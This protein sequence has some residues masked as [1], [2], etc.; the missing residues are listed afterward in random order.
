MSHAPLG[1]AGHLMPCDHL[2]ANLLNLVSFH[3]IGRL[4]PFPSLS[5][6]PH[7]D[8][9][10]MDSQEVAILCLAAPLKMATPNHA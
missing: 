4:L 7:R 5:A 6:V 9:H 1:W 8:S 3:K 10:A 2:R